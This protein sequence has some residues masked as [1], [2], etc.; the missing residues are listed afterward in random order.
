MGAKP[1]GRAHFCARIADHDPGTGQMARLPPVDPHLD[2]RYSL[3][4]SML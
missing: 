4:M 2:R 3:Q 1:Q